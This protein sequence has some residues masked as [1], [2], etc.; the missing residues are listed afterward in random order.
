[1]VHFLTRLMGGHLH[2]FTR[3]YDSKQHSHVMLLLMKVSI[4]IQ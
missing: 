2:D 3:K 1:M 4:F